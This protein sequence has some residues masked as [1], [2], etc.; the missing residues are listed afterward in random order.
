MGT[1]RLDAIGAGSDDV[2]SRGLGEPALHLRHAG[3]DRVTGEAAADEDDEAVQPRD[4]VAPVRQGV[5]VQLDL[6][7][8][9]DWRSH[10]RPRVASEAG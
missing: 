1:R 3:A 9:A 7:T 5:D 6:L 8:G 4:A 2:E 10:D